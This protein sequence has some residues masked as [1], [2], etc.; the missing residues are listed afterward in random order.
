MVILMKSF[1]HKGVLLTGLLILSAVSLY[2]ASLFTKHLP[3]SQIL[4]AWAV[5]AFMLFLVN[6][7]AFSFFSLSKPKAFVLLGSVALT[8]LF[9][10]FVFVTDQVT[11]IEGAGLFIFPAMVFLGSFLLLTV[12]RL[13]IDVLFDK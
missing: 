13:I 7:S 10:V 6:L 11:I 1:F 3:N 5:Y 4:G 8:A 2:I 12:I 9:L